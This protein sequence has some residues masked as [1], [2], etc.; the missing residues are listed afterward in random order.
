MR[1]IADRAGTGIGMYA[2]VCAIT[3][4]YIKNAIYTINWGKIKKELRKHRAAP[5]YLMAIVDGYLPGESSNT[6]PREARGPP[7]H[8]RRSTGLCV[9]SISVDGHVRRLPVTRVA[10]RCLD[11]RVH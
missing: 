3:A 1:D 10:R 6:T 8:G 4:V 9:E 2:D 7:L 5:E 11:Y